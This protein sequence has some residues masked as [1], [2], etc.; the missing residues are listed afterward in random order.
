MHMNK[1]EL[2]S[3]AKE[4]AKDFENPIAGVAYGSG[5]TTM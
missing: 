5:R 3:F 4:A 2:K 1:K